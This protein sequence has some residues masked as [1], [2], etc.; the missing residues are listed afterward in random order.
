MDVHVENSHYIKNLDHEIRTKANHLGIDDGRSM[1]SKKRL[2]EEA[3]RRV[4]KIVQ[5]QIKLQ[6]I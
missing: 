2:S 4:V 5:N 3:R 1:D 6:E